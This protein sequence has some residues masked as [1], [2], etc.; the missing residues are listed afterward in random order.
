MSIHS[1]RRTRKHCLSNDLEISASDLG[2]HA[3]VIPQFQKEKVL[4]QRMN[5]ATATTEWERGR[6]GSG[7]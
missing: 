3:L 1:P 5:T 6:C 2:H 4:T 7:A